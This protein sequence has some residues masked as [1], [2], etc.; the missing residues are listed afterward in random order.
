MR[1]RC[2]PLGFMKWSPRRL[3]AWLIGSSIAMGAVSVH[4]AD[5]SH[6][7]VV[8]LF[9]S[10]GCSSCPPA[11]ANLDAVSG[12]PDVIALNFAVT[13]WDGL[14][15]KD[16]FAKP[17]FT[18]RQW[19]YAQAIHHSRCSTPQV[20]VDGRR[21]GRRRQIRRDRAGWSAA[22][23]RRRRP[24]GE[25]GRRDLAIG[26][27]AE[28]AQGAD[29]WLAGTIRA[30]EVRDPSRRERRQDAAAQE[31]RPRNCADRRVER[32]AETCAC[33]RKILPC[34]PRSS[35]K[36]QARARSSPRRGGEGQWV[37]SSQER[38]AA[39]ES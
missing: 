36:R 20:V 12:R 7:T 21:D 37:R 17:Q 39:G 33:L 1:S 3:A 19:D 31:H 15:W 9:Q 2:W 35:S 30:P 13:Y 29:V 26:A 25:T 6:P 18:A 11:N 4:A 16:T 23:D 10:Q 28:P 24:R 8:E 32:A 5:P 14:G 27:G 22:A 38:F 34:A